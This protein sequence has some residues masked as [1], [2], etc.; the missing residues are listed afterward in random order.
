MRLIGHAAVRSQSEVH[1]PDD[2]KCG[3]LVPDWRVMAE[4]LAEP[5]I[6]VK[7]HARARLIFA[8]APLHQEPAREPRAQRPAPDLPG[9]D[10]AGGGGG[11]GGHYRPKEMK[12]YL[13][14]TS[15][16]WKTAKAQVTATAV[17]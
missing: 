5:L 8:D 1:K 2:H 7:F 9:V 10:P 14:G 3:L 13:T 6:E 15:P 16:R 11:A 12:A 4:A 17:K